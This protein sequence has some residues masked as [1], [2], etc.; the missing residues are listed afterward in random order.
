MK[1]HKSIVLCC[2]MLA[3]VALTPLDAS[4]QRVVD[5][6][7]REDD[8]PRPVDYGFGP[9]VPLTVGL[10]A[11][12]RI[13]AP[14]A[15]APM[16]G[17]PMAATSVPAGPANAH[18]AGVFGAPFPLPRL[19]IHSM[20]L[21]DGR[22][23]YFGSNSGGFQTARFDYVVWDPQQGTGLE[24]HQVLENFT[25]NDIFCAGQSLLADAPGK[26]LIVGGDL[27]INGVRNF[28]SNTSV[29]FN[30]EQNVIASGD[31]MQVARWYPSMVPLGNGEK[32]I[33]GGREEKPNVAVLAQTPE[34]FRADGAWKSKLRDAASDA[35]GY[36]GTTKNWFY[37][38]A[39]PTPDG[40][41]F[42]LSHDGRMFLLNPNGS[43]SITP[44]PGTRLWGTPGLTIVR[45][46]SSRLLAIRNARTAY[47][48]DLRTNPPT[49]TRVPNID[50]IRN[51]GSG[52]VLPNSSVFIN[53]GSEV[54]NQLQ[55]VSYSG[56]IFNPSSNQWT[57][58]A[59]AVMARLYHSTALLLPDATVFTGGGGS[60]GPVRNMNAEIFYPPYLY[61]AD[62]SGLPATRPTIVHAPNFV[63]LGSPSHFDVSVGAGEQIQRLVLVRTGS[64]THSVNFEQDT[65]QL[66]FTQTGDVLSV[67]T[68]QNPNVVIPGFHMLFAFNADHVPSVAKIIRFAN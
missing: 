23:M 9:G 2:A 35:F 64:D 27:K 42:V 57:P 16:A 58:T 68:P 22:V 19:P 33:L 55:G 63:Q 15:G 56:T 29:V 49:V 10:R 28:S 8:G 12:Q 43:G 1:V 7:P 30:P 14:M 60:P 59:S 37:P 34:L 61:R 45:Y 51:W 67:S 20:L 65:T 5:D 3:V 31:N 4:A 44:L 53:G 47:T 48:I 17:A 21:A 6:V 18:I 32:L 62:G 38:R 50:R 52:T 40:N 25:R 24:A 11:A 26:A 54:N 13:A 46:A 36:V 66:A 39:F 41:V